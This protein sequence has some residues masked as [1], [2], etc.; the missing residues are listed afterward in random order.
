MLM[1]SQCRARVAAPLLRGEA[2]ARGLAVSGLARSRRLGPGVEF[3]SLRDYAPGDDPRRI[4]WRASA[5]RPDPAT[6]V[7]LVSRDYVV[8]D[9]LRVL[10]YTV[11]G[12][13]LLYWDKLPALLYAAGLLYGLAQRLG[14]RVY[15]V[16]ETPWGR[17]RLHRGQ[18]REHL[19][20]L[21]AEACR[22]LT[23]GRGSTTPSV[24]L[25]ATA[26]PRRMDLAVLVADYSSRPSDYAEAAKAA[27]ARGASALAVLVTSPP[28]HRR[29]SW[30]PG[31]APLVLGGAAL[32]AYERFDSVARHMALVLAMLR[33]LRVRVVRVDGWPAAKAAQLGL[34]DAYLAARVRTPLARL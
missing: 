9:S 30:L 6:V 2:V 24:A 10:V 29:P 11:L 25:A 12:G 7:R 14:D 18:P 1:S 17:R 26:M 4:D 31:G 3:A 19:A 20:V 5:R 27:A 33:S 28:E 21:A 23:V 8:E 32:A 13:S 34:A 15:T 16:V 22:L